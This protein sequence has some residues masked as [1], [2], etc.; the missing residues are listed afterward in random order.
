[1]VR[2]R[3]TSNRF[4]EPLSFYLLN[5]VAT[6]ESGERAGTDRGDDLKFET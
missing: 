2:H 6:S 5:I 4:K 3:V 1:M